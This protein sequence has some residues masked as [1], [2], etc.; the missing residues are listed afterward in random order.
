MHLRP[1]NIQLAAAKAVIRGAIIHVKVD[2]EAVVAPHVA[3]DVLVVAKPH[4]WIPVIKEE[5][6]EWPKIL[7]QDEN[8]LERVYSPLYPSLQP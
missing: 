6:K 8:S 2:A 1:A 7:F 5:N 3:V 4:A